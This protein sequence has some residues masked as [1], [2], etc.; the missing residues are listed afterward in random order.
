MR[1]NSCSVQFRLCLKKEERKKRKMLISHVHDLPRIFFKLIYLSLINLR[2]KKEEAASFPISLECFAREILLIKVQ[3]T[4]TAYTSKASWGAPKTQR[5]TDRKG[6]GTRHH[7]L[8]ALASNPLLWQL[9][10]PRLLKDLGNM[11]SISNSS[12]ALGQDWQT[13]S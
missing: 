5:G 3:L 10:P 9:S 13:V 4:Y 1:K 11:W 6:C 7:P 8:V 2:D 12:S